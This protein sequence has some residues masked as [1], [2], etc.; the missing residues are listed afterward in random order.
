[1]RRSLR[2]PCLLIATLLKLCCSASFH[3]L[4]NRK[5]HCRLCGQIICSLPIKH[6]HRMAL[7]STLFVVDVQTRQVEEVGEGVDYGVRKKKIPNVSAQ[8]ARQEEEDK[9][10]RGVRICRNCRPILLCVLTS[11]RRHVLFYSFIS[12]V[13]S[14]NSK[15]KLYHRL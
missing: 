14:M 13:T 9:F 3:P 7:C 2:F 8:Q 15:C 1:M 6:P 5:H 11:S 12:G 4:T 10:L